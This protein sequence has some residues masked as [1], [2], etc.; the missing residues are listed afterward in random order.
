MRGHLVVGHRF[1]GIPLDRGRII[2]P[3]VLFIRRGRRSTGRERRDG[4][5]DEDDSDDWLSGSGTPDGH[6][7]LAGS[8]NSLVV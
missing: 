5:D 8:S 3:P 2:C 7:V 4:E 1:R 6:R